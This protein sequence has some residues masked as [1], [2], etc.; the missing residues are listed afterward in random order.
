MFSIVRFLIS[1]TDPLFDGSISFGF[2]VVVVNVV[3]NIVAIGIVLSQLFFVS[4][5]DVNPIEIQYS[6]KNAPKEQNQHQRER[7]PFAVR[8]HDRQTRQLSHQNQQDEN[9]GQP[10]AFMFKKRRMPHETQY[11]LNQEKEN[12]GIEMRAGKR[13]SANDVSKH[14]RNFENVKYGPND[15]KQPR[16]RTYF[17]VFAARVVPHLGATREGMKIES[18]NSEN[19]SDDESGLID[20]D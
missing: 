15:V 18:E 12:D 20:T 17:Y 2:V 5:N 1:S 13:S 9:A 6:G 7:Y 19:Q 4:F 16:R 10:H 14:R 3:V 8:P 11:R